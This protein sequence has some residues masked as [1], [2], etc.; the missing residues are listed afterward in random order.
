MSKTAQNTKGQRLQKVLAHAGLGSRRSCEDLITAGRV[1]VDGRVVRGLGTR[2][3]PDRQRVA[4]DGQPVQLD[5]EKVTIAL[6]K[7]EGVV[8]AM[9]D[10]EGR[11]TVAEYVYNRPERLFHVGRLDIETE[12]LI[13][14]T[15][16]GDLANNL[17]HPSHEVP[18]T[19]VATVEGR[20]PKS[21]G[22]ELYE[23]IELDDGVA[24]ADKF[25]ILDATP[26][27]TLVEITLHSGRNRVVRRMMEAAGFP[28]VRLVRT[29][30]GPIKLGELKPG[31]TRVLGREEVSSLMAFL[32]M[33]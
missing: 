6:N 22:R 27:H 30:I 25:R 14:L 12:G 4:V 26:Q 2:V 33:N 16:D 18:K 7:P 11:P 20:V 9:E 15:N 32:G 19:Y 21:L 23:G 8:S 17:M 10:P 28:V 29:R 13:L 3:D 31:R 5:T 1:A 24:W